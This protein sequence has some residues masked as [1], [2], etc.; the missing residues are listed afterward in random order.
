MQER[1]QNRKLYFKEQSYTTDTYVLPFIER[2]MEVNERTRV[3]EIGCGEGGNLDP[4]LQRGCEVYGID[5]NAEQISNAKEYLSETHSG[6]AFNLLFRDIYT[7]SPSEIGSFDL[8]IM[9]DVIEHIFDQEKFMAFVRSFLGKKGMI[10]FGFPPWYM[11]FGGH[12]QICDN[13]LLS[14]LPY[15]HLLPVSVYK[16][17]LR[18]FNEEPACVQALVEIKETGIS[19]QRFEKILRDEGYSIEQKELYL[20]NPNYEIKFGMKPL[21]Q[22]PL[23]RS[24]PGIREFLTTCSY[25]LLSSGVSR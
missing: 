24:L 10:F 25:Y 14:K 4:F 18:C 15:F 5:L 1:H 16:Y 7:V 17:M 20:V 22:L 8:I 3:L 21:R 6:K 19:I 11:P 23:L 12:Q 9:R 2:S 13:R